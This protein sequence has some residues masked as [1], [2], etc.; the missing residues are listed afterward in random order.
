MHGVTYCA[1]VFGNRCHCCH[2]GGTAAAFCRSLD[3]HV[4]WSLC[5]W[6]PT[7]PMAAPRTAIV[8]DPVLRGWSCPNPCRTTVICNGCVAARQAKLQVGAQAPVTLTCEIHTILSFT[9]EGDTPSR[10][11]PVA[12]PCAGVTSTLKTQ[13]RVGAHENRTTCQSRPEAL[14]QPRH[15][16]PSQDDSAPQRLRKERSDAVGVPCL[17]ANTPAAG[18]VRRPGRPTF[19]GA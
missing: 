18:W 8:R 14:N 10:P 16:A 12:S 15:M 3:G 5:W 1:Q 9:D 19:H 11:L 4:R 13:N 6:T 7:G 17:Q 2:L